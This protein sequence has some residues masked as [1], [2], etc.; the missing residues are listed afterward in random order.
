MRIS[1]NDL[2]AII[3][4]GIVL[5]AVAAFTFIPNPVRAFAAASGDTLTAEQ[6]AIQAEAARV[7]EAKAV[8]AQIDRQY[9]ENVKQLEEKSVQLQNVTVP[10][11]GT[12]KSAVSGLYTANKVAGVAIQSPVSEGAP[13]TGEM[14]CTTW[15]V[16]S[17]KSPQAYATCTAAAESVN[18]TLGPAV[19][20]D[21]FKKGSSSGD[22]STYTTTIGVPN[23]FYQ[24]GAKYAAVH[25]MP[26]G[27]FEIL[28]NTSTNPRTVQIPVTTGAG[29]YALIKLP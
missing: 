9:E 2:K 4:A 13:S 17:K 23:S 5:A 24:E 15:D 8:Q 1:K 26:G 25:V 7:A 28:E 10:G 11:A 27:K 14:R 16:D 19:E 21:L 29:V 3:G 18:A 12:I 6:E 22:G 20:I